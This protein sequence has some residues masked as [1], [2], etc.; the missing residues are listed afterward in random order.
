MVC[1]YVFPSTD[2]TSWEL[3]AY[4]LICALRDLLFL[5]AKRSNSGIVFTINRNYDTVLKPGWLVAHRTN[6]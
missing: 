6:S 4:I 1:T 3:V 5:A 2:C